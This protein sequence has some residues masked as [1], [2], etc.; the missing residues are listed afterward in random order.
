MGNFL[1]TG[2]TKRLLKE[3]CKNHKQEGCI[4]LTEILMDQT[5]YNYKSVQVIECFIALLE[6]SSTLL[7]QN[8]VP[9]IIKNIAN[10]EQATQ[11]FSALS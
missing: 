3:L 4:S 5:S 9:I 6:K 11:V 10:V 1:T 8:T 7:S 2:M